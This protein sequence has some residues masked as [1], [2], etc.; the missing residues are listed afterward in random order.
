MCHFLRLIYDRNSDVNSSISQAAGGNP[1]EL[2]YV[3][4][5]HSLGGLI[6]SHVSVALSDDLCRPVGV[7]K[8]S[9]FVFSAPALH[10][11]PE[12]AQPH[13]ILIGRLLAGIA[14]QAIVT[15]LPEGVFSRNEAATQAF[16]NDPLVSQG[17]IRAR[18]GIQVLNG[19]Q[20]I[21]DPKPSPLSKLQAPVLCVHGACDSLTP[22]STSEF[23]M[24]NAGSQ[25]KQLITY[26]GALHEAW[27]DAE[28]EDKIAI[29][30][31]SFAQQSMG[32]GQAHSPVFHFEN[33][34]KL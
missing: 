30:I 2:P 9:G 21:L 5:G 28:F 12:T 3:V 19:Q 17:F 32:I 33:G 16:R 8:P 10:I 18:F 20:S 24:N 25:S 31:A 7:P 27:E 1:A 26:P 13:L 6:C 4:S 34:E 29:D 22:L 15:R 23:V 14:P 11:D